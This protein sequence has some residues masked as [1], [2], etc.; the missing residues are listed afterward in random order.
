[1]MRATFELV[2][3]V[4][5]LMMRPVRATTYTLAD[6]WVGKDFLNGWS[7]WTGDDPTNGRVNYVNQ[8]Y[9]LANNLTYA[10]SS[11]FVMRADYKKTV[12]STARGR[13]SVRISSNSAYGDSLIIIDLA[14]MPEGLSTWPAYVHVYRLLHST[15]LIAYFVSFWTISQQGPWPA[16]GE[17]VGDLNCDVEDRI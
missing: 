1:M 2:L 16:G 4:L 15:V 13:D 12:S 11:K 14:H 3:F 6:T 17:I 8:S 10:S 5:P 7:W 9:A